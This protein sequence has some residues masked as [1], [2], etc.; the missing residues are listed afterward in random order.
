MSEFAIFSCAAIVF[1]AIVGS[2]LNALSFRYNTGISIAHGRSRCMSCGH[3]LGVLDLVPIFSFFFLKG[4]CHYCNSSISMQYPAVEV[5]AALLSWGIYLLNTTPLLYAF[6]LVVWMTILFLV[7][8]DFR[9]MIIPRECSWLL[10]ILSLVYL[11][12]NFTSF[13]HPFLSLLAGPILAAPLL[14]LSL[15]SKE[16]WMGW[17]DGWF[18]LSLGWLLGLWVGLTAIM[19]AVWSG[20]F[21]GLLLIGISKWNILGWVTPTASS[22][23]GR[24]GFTMR[25]EIPF[26]PFLAL[27]AAIAY[28]F[29]VD[30]FSTLSFIW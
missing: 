28:F 25:S 26:A 30:F 9:H 21:V 12:F 27:G 13:A 5:M 11:A 14:F 22:H 24:R 1:G 7:V 19:I 20:A 16:Q 3:T 6:W 23:T 17:G 4:R 2:F 15:I 18:E 10:V 8:Y 29:H